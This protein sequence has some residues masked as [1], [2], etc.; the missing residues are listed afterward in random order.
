LDATF[1]TQ[2]GALTYGERELNR[3]F[4]RSRRFGI[5]GV[6]VVMVVVAALALAFGQNNANPTGLY[7]AIFLI[8]FGFMAVVLRL[9]RRDLD[10][11]EQHAIAEASGPVSAV[12]DPTTANSASLLTAL[13]VGPVDRKAI[14]DATAATWNLGRQSIS[15]GGVML[16]LIACAVVPWQLWQTYWSL[17]LFVP[18]IVGYALYMLSKVMGAGGTLAPAYELS[19]PTMEPLGLRMTEAPKV[20]VA[21]RIARRGV[22]KHIAGAATY[23]GQR[24]GRSVRIRL[25]ARTTTQVA[26][27]YPI[28]VIR[29]REGRLRAGSGAPA[30]VESVLAPLAASPL[31]RGVT[32]RGGEEGIVVERKDSRA[33]WMCD[34]WLAE[35]L[36]D[37]LSPT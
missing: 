9:Q 13:A 31:W 11:G 5:I 14:E 10:T 26:G 23:E 19:E 24:H 4:K 25:G 35:R 15:G 8:V 7:I 28:F 29:N 32:A 30:A 37:A 34:L 2:G 20:A 12:S 17:I 16:V 33:S 3:D 1:S 27:S 36:A 6:V 21:P 22:E 18:L